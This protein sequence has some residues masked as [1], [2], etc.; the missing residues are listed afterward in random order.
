MMSNGNFPFKDG[1]DIDYKH[2]EV[3]EQEEAELSEAIE[4]MMDRSAKHL[5]KDQLTKLKEHVTE[6]KDIFRM[7][8]VKDPPVNVPRMNVQL[9]YVSALIAVWQMPFA[10]SMPAR[11]TV[12]KVWFNSDFIRNSHSLLIRCQIYH[13]H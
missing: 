4:S 5:S 13:R 11:L 7:R 6:F 1:D 2:V 10:H 8:L 3:S 12:S 9:K